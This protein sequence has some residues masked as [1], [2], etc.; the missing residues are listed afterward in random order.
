MMGSVVRDPHGVESS[1]ET[2]P[3]LGLLDMETEMYPEKTTTQVQAG[4]ICDSL[5]FPGRIDEVLSG[6]EIHM[7]RSTSGG[8]ARPLFRIFTR[9]AIPADVEDGLAQPDGRAWGTY[10][11]GIFDNDGFRAM[12]LEDLA[13]RSGKVGL[14]AS[15][16]FSFRLWKEEQYDRLARYVGSHVDV[17]RVLKEVLG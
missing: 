17:N 14:K 8:A 11:H 10:I 2:I 4:L 3:G 7:G 1:M 12:F 6:Y 16:S 15:D 9:D 13:K 5:P